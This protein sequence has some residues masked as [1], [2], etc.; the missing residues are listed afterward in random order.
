VCSMCECLACVCLS[1][2]GVGELVCVCVFL[3]ECLCV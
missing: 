2:C 1:V 3:C